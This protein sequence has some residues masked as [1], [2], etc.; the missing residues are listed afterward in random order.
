MLVATNDSDTSCTSRCI[1]GP[2]SIKS[3]VACVELELLFT[4]RFKA[5][6]D[7]HLTDDTIWDGHFLNK[8]IGSMAAPR[9]P[10]QP[11]LGQ[12]S[13]IWEDPL[14][15]RCPRNS[16]IIP[17]PPGPIWT[18]T[19]WDLGSSYDRPKALI[20]VSFVL[21]SC[22]L[23]SKF[24]IEAGSAL[25]SMIFWRVRKGWGFNP[26]VSPSHFKRKLDDKP[27]ILG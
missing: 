18:R 8:Q 10:E 4:L 19:T 5:L 26:Q 15:A 1:Q 16:R 22:A 17:V 25:L 21:I 20:Y 14:H 24:W 7:L 11:R 9:H 13:N 6:K 12:V 23:F 27:S 3:I 2:S